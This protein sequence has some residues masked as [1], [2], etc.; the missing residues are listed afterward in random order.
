MKATINQKTAFDKTLKKVKNK[1]LVNLGDIMLD[2]GYS[3]ATAHNPGK[4]LTS[5]A[6]WQMLL[7]RI[8]DAEIIARFMEIMRDEDKRASLAAGVELLK[9]KDRY[10]AGKLK[11]TQLEEEIGQY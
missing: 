8:N 11:V 10:P 1:E 2:S 7:N 5:K 9:L 3:A 6:G 4:N